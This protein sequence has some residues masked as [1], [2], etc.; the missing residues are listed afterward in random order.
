MA[1]KI[2]GRYIMKDVLEMVGDEKI[3]DFVGRHKTRYN[4]IYFE[5]L[6][7]DVVKQRN[8]LNLVFEKMFDQKLIG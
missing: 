8:A 2:M 7:E 1:T 6:E 4:S 5:K 3:T